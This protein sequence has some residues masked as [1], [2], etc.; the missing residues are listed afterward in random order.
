MQPWSRGSATLPRRACPHADT[1]TRRYVPRYGYILATSV[2]MDANLSG[3]PGRSF[4][5]L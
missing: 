3:M 2:T 1:P 4:F 5:C